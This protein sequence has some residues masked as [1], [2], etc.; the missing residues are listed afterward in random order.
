M[1]CGMQV[2]EGGL[3]G[4]CGTAFGD[5]GIDPFDGQ[6]AIGLGDGLA[7][8]PGTGQVDLDFG[9]IDIPI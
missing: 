8:E 7:V 2:F 4:G 1:C 6:M 9:G 5:I 3:C